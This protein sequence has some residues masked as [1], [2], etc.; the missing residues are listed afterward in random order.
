MSDS[1]LPSWP[2]STV[3]KVFDAL[4]GRLVLLYHPDLIAVLRRF[5][6]FL[7]PGGI[8]PFEEMDME[9]LSQ[10]PTSETF[11]RVRSWILG[12]F[13]AGGTELNMGASCYLLS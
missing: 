2:L 10:V 7:K 5:E 8:I 9:T 1:R 11:T 12:G 6:N 13:Q 3:Q 4:I